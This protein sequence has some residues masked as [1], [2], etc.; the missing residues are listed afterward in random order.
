MGAEVQL[1]PGDTRQNVIAE[2]N[3]SHRLFQI[4]GHG[5]IHGAITVGAKDRETKQAVPFDIGG[6]KTETLVHDKQTGKIVG[7][8]LGRV[9]KPNEVGDTI[10]IPARDLVTEPVHVTLARRFNIAGLLEGHRIT[11]KD[12]FKPPEW[13][14]AAPFKTP[15]H[16]EGRPERIANHIEPVQL[17]YL[18]DDEVEIDERVCTKPPPGNSAP[19]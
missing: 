19:R 13:Q 12:C 10:L 14:T 15:V 7:V 8:L 17:N 5:T 18:F 9:V 2:I 6:H 16:I 1:L 4:T 11:P 3:G